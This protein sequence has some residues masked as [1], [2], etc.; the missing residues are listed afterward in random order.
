MLRRNLNDVARELA[1]HARQNLTTVE[2]GAVPVRLVEEGANPLVFHD[3]TGSVV[4]VFGNDNYIAESRARRE[5]QLVRQ[6]LPGLAAEEVGFGL[7]RD[8][9]TWAMVVRCDDRPYR[10]AAGKRLQREM[11][12]IGLENAVRDAWEAAGPRLSVG[13]DLPLPPSGENH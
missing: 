10:T 4:G 6:R 3:I 8:G 7:S 2:R 11:L 5:V 9:Y 12:K 1:A 13:F